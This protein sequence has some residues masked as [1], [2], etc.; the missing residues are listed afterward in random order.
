MPMSLEPSRPW[1]RASC[2]CMDVGRREVGRF[3]F[4]GPA[5]V[6]V[7]AP[8]LCGSVLKEH[9]DPTMSV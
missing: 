3:S 4:Y 8:A 9:C 2:T 1:C 5:N 6:T 7:M